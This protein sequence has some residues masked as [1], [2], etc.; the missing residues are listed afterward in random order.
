[1]D[2]REHHGNTDLAS[3]PRQ[4][5]VHI[6]MIPNM[7]PWS[8]ANDA[9]LSDRNSVEELWFTY[10]PTFWKI[11]CPWDSN[12]VPQSL[13]VAIP[14]FIAKITARTHKPK[15]FDYFLFLGETPWDGMLLGES[16]SKSYAE[17][18][19]SLVY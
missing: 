6:C 12:N 15:S 7:N 11:L 17:W 3:Y 13:S 1:M 19:G 2:V 16:L 18:W 8:S 4:A 9:Q 5:A 10:I 14:G